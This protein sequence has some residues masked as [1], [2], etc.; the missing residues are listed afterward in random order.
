LQCRGLRE[1]RL[2]TRMVE[3]L[4]RVQLDAMIGLARLGDLT[5]FRVEV[6]GAV[7]TSLCHGRGTGVRVPKRIAGT[8]VMGID[9]PKQG[10][11]LL[12]LPEGG[13]FEVFEAR[14]EDLAL[15]AGAEV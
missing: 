7:G 4:G 14:P 13:G 8:V 11:S 2:G 15:D 12:R 5:G 6:I 10:V 1:V 3:G 9:A